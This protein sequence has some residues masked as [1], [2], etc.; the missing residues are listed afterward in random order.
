MPNVEYGMIRLSSSVAVGR[1]RSSR[2]VSLILFTKTGFYILGGRKPYLWPVQCLLLN[3]KILKTELNWR[4]N[5]I[6]IKQNT[7]KHDHPS[8][9]FG[10]LVKFMETIVREIE[11][12]FMIAEVETVALLLTHPTFQWTPEGLFE[13][14][15]A[16]MHSLL[17]PNEFAVLWMRGLRSIEPRNEFREVL[18]KLKKK[19][20]FG[21]SKRVMEE[22]EVTEAR[23]QK[24][25]YQ[26]VREFWRNWRE[27]EVFLNLSDDSIELPAAPKETNPVGEVLNVEEVKPE[28][29]EDYKP[30]FTGSKFLSHR[31][32]FENADNL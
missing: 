9:I 2:F 23:I 30:Q 5:S 17:K 10:Q 28:P 29:I 8:E 19:K 24:S 26:V 15:A 18:Q 27:A 1:G 31:N 4:L 22:L 6:S 7:F 25:H 16:Y 21:N 20:R 32:M 11:S 13:F 12:M 3:G 14:F